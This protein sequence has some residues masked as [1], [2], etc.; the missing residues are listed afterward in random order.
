MKLVLI[1]GILTTCLAAALVADEPATSAG[2]ALHLGVSGR[3][4]LPKAFE[5]GEPVAP[6]WWFENKTDKPVFVK[7]R[8]ALGDLVYIIITPDKRELVCDPVKEWHDD[9]AAK[10][11]VKT[12]A[13]AE[14]TEFETV[15]ADKAGPL[16]GFVGL[17]DDKGHRVVNDRLNALPAHFLIEPGEYQ[18]RARWRNADKRGWTGELESDS[19]RFEVLSADRIAEMEKGLAI[20]RLDAQTAAEITAEE[21]LAAQGRGTLRITT[22]RLLRLFVKDGKKYWEAEFVGDQGRVGRGHR[23]TVQV[24]GETGNAKAVR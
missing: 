18:M 9:A 4:T 14:D 24:D 2:L 17:V 20:S 23:V 16:Q 1:V 5:Q 19:V 21:H 3:E 8:P 15:E 11:T 10:W 6:R 13:P 22:E 7:Q 12:L